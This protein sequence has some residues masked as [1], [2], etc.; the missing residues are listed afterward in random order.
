MKSTTGAP[1]KL[2]RG[3]VARAKSVTR[4]ELRS[5]SIGG[6]IVTDVVGSIILTSFTNE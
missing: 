1:W 5:L 3:V 2:L 6:K 4:S